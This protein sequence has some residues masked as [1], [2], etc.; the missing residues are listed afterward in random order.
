MNGLQHVTVDTTIS[1]SDVDVCAAPTCCLPE[2]QGVVSWRHKKACRPTGRSACI[3]CV[4]YGQSW[5]GLPSCLLVCF[6]MDALQFALLLLLFWNCSEQEQSHIVWH[7]LLHST[8]ARLLAQHMSEQSVPTAGYSARPLCCSWVQL[9]GWFCTCRG[10]QRRGH[11][12]TGTAL[13][14]ASGLTGTDLA[15]DM[16][17]GS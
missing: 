8:L 15:F 4:L 13:D 1:C 11:H 10:V 12:G 2:R 7:R 3:V 5:L 14:M 16:A 9:S 6:S 17:T